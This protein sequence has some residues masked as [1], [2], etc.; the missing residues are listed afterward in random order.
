MFSKIK[1]YFFLFIILISTN[2]F[3]EDFT[4][5]GKFWGHER[6]TGN[7]CIVTVEIKPG[8]FSRSRDG[9][10]L[11]KLFIK[12][13]NTMNMVMKEKIPYESIDDYSLLHQ[14]DYTVHWQ[15]NY[16]SYYFKRTLKFKDRRGEAAWTRNLHWLEI[17]TPR[18]QYRC[19]LKHKEWAR[20]RFVEIW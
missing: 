18:G 19:D 15:N 12:D 10:H 14:A 17:E 4:I 3:S 1:Q 5:A 13:S 6:R 2:T 7:R 20:G 16:N 9:K 11:V 8:V